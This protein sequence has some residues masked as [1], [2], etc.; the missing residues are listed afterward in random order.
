MKKSLNANYDQKEGRAL[1]AEILWGC[2]SSKI[3]GTNC[4]DKRMLT[5]ERPSS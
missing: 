4:V 1:A 3:T 5:A 2:R